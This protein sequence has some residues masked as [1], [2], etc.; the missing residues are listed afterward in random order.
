MRTL[1]IALFLSFVV[2]L[3]LTR[4]VRDVALKRGWFDAELGGRRLHTRPKPRLGGIGIAIAFA[5]PLVGLA[6]WRNDFSKLLLSDQPLLISLVGGGGLMLVTGLIDDLKGTRALIKLAAQI[7]AALL[8]FQVG[9]QI[10]A[11][12]LPFGVVLRFGWMSLPV[13]V[14]WI[15]LVTNAVNLIDGLD[16]LATG[17]VA[18]AT[19]TLFVFSV[20]QGDSL[21]AVLLVSLLG[22]T[23]GFLLFNL[24]P[25]SIFLGDSGSLTLGF[26][27]AL[28]SVHSS[29]K[30]AALFSIVGAVLVLGLPI[31]DLGLAVVRRGLTGKPLFSADQHHIH[32]QLLRR[33]MTQ[34]QTFGFLV[35]AAVVLELAALTLIYANDAVQALVLTA[36]VGLGY[37]AFRYLGYEQIIRSGRRVAVS[38]DMES[39]A[40]AR[41][42]GVAGLRE[43]LGGSASPDRIWDVVLDFADVADLQAVELQVGEAMRFAWDRTNPI[44]ERNVHLQGVALKRFAIGLGRE[45]VG[46]LTVTRFR[47][48]EVFAPHDDALC[49]AMADAIALAL[50]GAEAASDDPEV[51]AG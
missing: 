17:V 35:G 6:L 18:L 48:H 50:L 25:A 11:L 42:T 38:R 27:L 5:A 34:R 7:A 8:V 46:E 41:A 31:F 28:I 45:Q 12:R 20:S 24:N 26:L 15:V 16:G 36:L 10:E 44:G 51:S 9:I 22:S 43:R 14:L 32:H 1:V 13:T 37:L 21:A 19:G 29:Q 39:A 30:S 4:V 3:V 40:R 49:Q 33:G 23:L 2:S 47:E